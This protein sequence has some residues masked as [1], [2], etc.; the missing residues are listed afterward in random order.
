MRKKLIVPVFM[1]FTP[2]L[3]V[4]GGFSVFIFSNNIVTESNNVTISIEKSLDYGEIK[5]VYLKDG[6]YLNELDNLNFKTYLELGYENALLVR[7]DNPS[8]K[9]SF[10]IEYTP[11]NEPL[12][13]VSLNVK[14]T[15]KDSDSRGISFASPL[16]ENN[17]YPISSSLLDI[18]SP[19]RA[20]L[21]G[22][23]DSSVFNEI[24][25]LPQ[26]ITYQSKLIQFRPTINERFQ[27]FLDFSYLWFNE[28]YLGKSITGS[29]SPSYHLSRKMLEE[30]MKSNIEALNNSSIDISFYLEGSPL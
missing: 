6:Q 7:N 17:P 30:K 16:G 2:L 23:A 11:P 29:F 18:I 24:E 3:L 21:H 8:I 10:L 27:V 1:M 4:G 19:K 14:L 26:H 20:S 12:N 22:Y 9:R 28:T 13:D 15:L 25:S 5:L